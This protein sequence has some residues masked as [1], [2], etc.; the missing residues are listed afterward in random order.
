MKG[1]LRFNVIPLDGANRLQMINAE[2]R[3]DLNNPTSKL[4]VLLTD[5]FKRSEARRIIFDAFNKY[6]VL[7]PLLGGQLSIKLSDIEP[8]P[9][10]ERSFTEEA[11]EY[12]QNNLPIESMSDGVKAFIGIIISIMADDPKVITIDEP[13]AFLHPSLTFKLGKEVGNI[14]NKDNSKKV[15]VSTHSANFLMG[16]IQS[17]VPLNIVRLTYSNNVPTARLLESDKISKLMRHPL[18]R[19]VGTLN[20]LFYEYV[21]VTESDS[22]R[23]FYQEINERLLAFT[24]EKGI[25]NCLFL[26]AQNKQTV[27]EIMKPLREMGIPCAGIVDIDIVKEGGQNWTNLMEGSFVPELTKRET[28]TSRSNIW[29]KFKE[30]DDKKYAEKGIK[31]FSKRN[32]GISVLEKSDSESCNNLF[33]RLEEY[34]VFVVRNGELESWL[35][36]LGVTNKYKWLIEIFEKMGDNP[37][38]PDY[39]KPK[40]DDVWEFIGNIKNWFM[41]PLRKG[42]PE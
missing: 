32:G 23:A 4:S 3:G 28:E 9:L 16:S 27:H 22:D 18:L 24:P 19:S 12:H 8:S 10:L 6:F 33:N 38:S 15:C 26:N 41:N 34:G 36:H 2:D 11:I 1:Y 17:G 39:L 5:D 13:E 40:N 37:N 21:V 31:D 29:N 30:I 25:H 35:K 42:I 14:L 20:G 7:D